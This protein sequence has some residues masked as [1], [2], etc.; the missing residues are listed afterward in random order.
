LDLKEEVTGGWRRLNN[1]EL[2]NFYS[3]HIKIICLRRLRW[4]GHIAR[5]EEI[6]KA[7]I[8]VGKPEGRPIHR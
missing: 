7:Y 3:S 5:M 6:R 1:E 4:M 8:L 2:H